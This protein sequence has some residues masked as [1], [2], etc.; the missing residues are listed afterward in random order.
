MRSLVVAIA[1][2][3]TTPLSA[4]PL[5]KAIGGGR[6]QLLRNL[7]VDTDVFG[8]IT[9]T[10]GYRSDGSSSPVPDTRGSRIAG[11]VHDALYSA[12][13]HLRF[14]HG[15]PRGWSRA[16]ADRTYCELLREGT[17]RWH[18]SVNCRAV[19]RFGFT[20]H[21]WERLRVKRERR[22]AQRATRPAIGG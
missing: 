16:Q 10:R 21:A 4:E 14:G 20:R 12:S 9:L 1:L 18:A 22:W 13:G 17:P 7:S 5:Y 3:V 15:Y 6:Y 11:F 2:L 8:P 19:R